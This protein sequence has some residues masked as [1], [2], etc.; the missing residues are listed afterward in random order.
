MAIKRPIGQSAGWLI[1]CPIK[2]PIVWPIVCLGRWPA[3]LAADWQ[4]VRQA[5]RLQ[6]RFGRGISR[7]YPIFPPAHALQTPRGSLRFP[8]TSSETWRSLANNVQAVQPAI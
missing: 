4:A 2:G 1:M 3:D 7:V 6:G 8:Q 5:R